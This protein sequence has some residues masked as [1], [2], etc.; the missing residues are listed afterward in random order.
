MGGTSPLLKFSF[1][2]GEEVKV[3]QSS[4]LKN[5]MVMSGSFNPVHTGHFSLA[6]IAQLKASQRNGIMFEI[7]LKNADKGVLGDPEK[8]SDRILLIEQ[9]Q[10]D[11]SDDVTVVLSHEPLFLQKVT[12]LSQC[13]MVLGHDTYLR[14]LDTKYYN[15]SQ[16]KLKEALATFKQQ[17]TTFVVG[18]RICADHVFHTGEVQ[19]IPEEYREMFSFLSEK[20]FRQDISSTEIR[21][22]T[23][24]F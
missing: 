16:E 19:M 17:G 4:L 12:Y 18:G 22:K 14:L 24:K 10:K 3:E 21:A 6:R 7:A 1:K 13:S 5:Y 23:N 20:E 11:Y 15:H 2:K 8:I 9:L